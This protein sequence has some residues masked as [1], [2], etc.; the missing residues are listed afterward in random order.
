VSFHEPAL[1]F[2]SQ[3]FSFLARRPFG[4]RLHLPDVEGLV[5][6]APQGGLSCVEATRR[7]SQ[8]RHARGR[9]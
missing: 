9:H 3:T 4:Q 7:T 5:R 1:L 8:R 6:R 2:K